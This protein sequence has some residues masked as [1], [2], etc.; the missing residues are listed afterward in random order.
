MPGNIVQLGL[1]ACSIG[2]IVQLVFLLLL[3]L[4]L[5]TFSSLGSHYLSLDNIIQLGPLLLGYSSRYGVQLGLSHPHGHI[6]GVK[7]LLWG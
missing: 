4:F 7:W 6:L 5:L 2:H 1:L 3:T